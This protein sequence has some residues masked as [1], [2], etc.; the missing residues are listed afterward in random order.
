MLVQPGAATT[1]GGPRASTDRED[2]L[3]SALRVRLDELN[4]EYAVAV[5]DMTLVGVAD[6]GDDVADLGT[7]AFNRE[8]EFALAETI[9]GRVDQ[10][11]R[12]L[13]RLAEGRYGWCETCT[14]EIPVARLAAFPMATLCV[15][16][17]SLAERR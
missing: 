12:A 6:A 4:A 7:K 2:D 15:R 16:C 8:Q 5:A 14:D 10:V 11:E 3:R 13:E 17:K 9:R 1:I